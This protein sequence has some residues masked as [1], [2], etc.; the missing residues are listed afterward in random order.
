[1]QE[2]HLRLLE[3]LDEF[4]KNTDNDNIEWD[5][6]LIKIASISKNVNKCLEEVEELQKDMAVLKADSHPPIFSKKDLDKIKQ[7]LKKLENG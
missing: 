5:N 1:M 6:L 2:K 3:E 4:F 7:R